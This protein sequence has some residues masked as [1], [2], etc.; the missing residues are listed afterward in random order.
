M[1][2]FD[3]HLNDFM[4][5]LRGEVPW[6]FY[7][8]LLLRA[9][10]VYLILLAGFRL[11]GKR[12]ASRLTRNELAAVAS[13]A[14]S[15]GIPLQQ[16]DRGLLP[17]IIVAAI[18]IMVQQLVA[19]IAAGNESFERA[20][21]GKI[22]ALVIDGVLQTAEMKNCHMSR[23]RIFSQLR[24]NKVKQLGEVKRFYLEANGSFT[25]I[26]H[27]DPPP[28]L[29]ILPDIDK[30]FIAEQPEADHELCS[31]CGNSRIEKERHCR[32]CHHEEWVK[33]VSK[34]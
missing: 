27:P 21:Q 17:G 16:P 4:R 15:I 19:Y 22:S 28:G 10:V 11:M 34:P 13:L 3:I 26:S 12:M 23:E 1:D 6:E 32:Q 30:A 25:F 18:V 33:A 9:V 14:A 24:N 20:T 7:V 5:I 31:Y 2:K 8:E 29:C